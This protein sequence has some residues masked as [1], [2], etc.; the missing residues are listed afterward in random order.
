MRRISSGIRRISSGIRPISSGN[1][2]ES[3]ESPAEFVDSPAE[4]VNPLAESVESPAESTLQRNA[5]ESPAESVGR[6]PPAES[7]NPLAESVSSGIR[8]LFLQQSLPSNLQRNVVDSPA[9]NLQRSCR[10]IR[11]ISSGMDPAVR[12]AASR[13]STDRDYLQRNPLENPTD[14]PTSGSVSSFHQKT[15]RCVVDVLYTVII[16][17][18]RTS[19]GFDGF[20]PIPP[21]Y[22]W[23]PTEFAEDNVSYYGLGLICV[24]YRICCCD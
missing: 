23:T 19:H 21:E 15:L 2:W 16:P 10:C 6:N 1:P 5:S 18:H 7:V 11:P 20:P 9:G 13:I 14:S 3:V 17:S 12:S 8:R 4:S 22:R 24:S